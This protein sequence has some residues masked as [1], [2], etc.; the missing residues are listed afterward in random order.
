MTIV[1][2]INGPS[3]MDQSLPRLRAGLRDTYKLLTAT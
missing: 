3:N 1:N 2:K